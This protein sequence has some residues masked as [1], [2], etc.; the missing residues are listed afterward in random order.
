MPANV[1]VQRI[2]LN[3]NIVAQSVHVLCI[4]GSR[5]NGKAKTKIVCSKMQRTLKVI[6]AKFVGSAIFARADTRSQA[7]RVSAAH[8]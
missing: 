6:S 3:M 2:Q 5:T 4:C 7:A 1:C 8:R